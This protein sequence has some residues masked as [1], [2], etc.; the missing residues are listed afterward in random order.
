M[1]VQNFTISTIRGYVAAIIR[2]QNFYSLLPSQITESQLV[3][4]IC[5][6]KENLNLSGS[7]MRISIAA[8][9]YFYRNIL[10]KTALVAKIPYPKKEKHIPVILN[11]SEIRLLLNNCQNLKHQLLLKLIYSAG[12]RRSE[13]INITINDFDRIGMQVI[14]RQGKG[15][16]DRYSILSHALVK[17]LDL[18]IKQYQ[19]TD[20]LF[21]G[22]VKSE[23]ISASLIRWAMKQAL[24]NAH[25]TK[26][27]NIHSLRHS[28][29]S[30]LLSMNT[31]VITIQKLLGHADIRTTTAYLH[32]NHHPN[33][34]PQ[35]PLDI[36]FK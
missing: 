27:V 2:L 8:I 18:Y 4:F 33:N 20:R 11:G 7:T 29:A 36:I 17:D 12:L 21:Y 25:I 16:K 6:L 3:N 24:K 10:N 26:N 34:K 1:V 5:H 35:S 14:I 15:K 23:P 31:D 28:F 30:H 22:R 19:P 32:L 9:K 13:A